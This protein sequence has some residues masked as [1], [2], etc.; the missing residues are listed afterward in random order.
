MAIY[1]VWVG[2]LFH[3]EIVC[4]AFL[5]MLGYV[6]INDREVSLGENTNCL[7]WLKKLFMVLKGL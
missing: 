5:K 2:V 3:Y 1:C 7:T 6:A 4:I